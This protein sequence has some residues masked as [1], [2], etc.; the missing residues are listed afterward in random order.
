M[1]CRPERTAAEAVTELG[2]PTLMAMTVPE[3]Q[4]ARGTLVWAPLNCQCQPLPA[5][6]RL[7]VYRGQQ[8]RGAVIM[9]GKRGTI[10]L[11]P[12]RGR[13]RDVRN[14]GELPGASLPHCEQTYR[15]VPTLA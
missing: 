6:F 14:S 3:V 15:H 9:G 2:S 1:V 13:Q 12:R 5:F 4:E 10:N 11:D 7:Q 8:T